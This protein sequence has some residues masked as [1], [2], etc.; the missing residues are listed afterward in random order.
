MEAKVNQVAILT[1]ELA[2]VV[3]QLKMHGVTEKACKEVVGKVYS[4]AMVKPETPKVISKNPKVKS[5]KPK[6]DNDKDKSVVYENHER[7]ILSLLKKALR[8][9]NI[10]EIGNMMAEKAKGCKSRTNWFFFHKDCCELG[11][12]IDTAGYEYKHIKDEQLK[13]IIACV[14]AS[15]TLGHWLEECKW[16]KKQLNEKKASVKELKDVVEEEVIEEEEPQES[17]NIVLQE[18]TKVDSFPVDE[19]T[20]KATDFL[21]GMMR[22]IHKEAGD[23]FGQTLEILD[24]TSKKT[25]KTAWEAMNEKLQTVINSECAIIPQCVDGEIIFFALNNK[26]NNSLIK[27]TFAEIVSNPKWAMEQ[28]FIEKLDD[29]ETTKF[30][31]KTKMLK[32]EVEDEDN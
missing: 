26:I 4:Q 3:E 5:V 16:L 9:Q 20:Q 14:P 28:G 23:N 1:A 15:D 29:S 2:K 13:D 27:E 6:V 22:M 30:L 32:G 10:Q 8:C 24:R 21:L 7:F 17:T 19:K 11:Q 31:V 18:T 25:G 12:A